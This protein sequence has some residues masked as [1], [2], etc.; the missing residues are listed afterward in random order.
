MSRKRTVSLL[1]SQIG[2]YPV[3]FIGCLFSKRT[4]E[5]ELIKNKKLITKNKS[6][7][8]YQTTHRSYC[9][10]KKKRIPALKDQRTGRTNLEK[11]DAVNK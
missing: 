8:R 3:Q 10:K 2:E 4:S 6:S 5:S 1:L 9:L 7:R 11:P